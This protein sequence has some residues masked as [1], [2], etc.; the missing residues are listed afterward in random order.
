MQRIDFVAMGC[1][2]AVFHDSDA[3]E[4]IAL[5]Q[6]VPTWF[7]E[8]EQALSRF[9]P[10]SELSA[11]N[12]FAGYWFQ[13]SEVLWDVLVAALDGAARTAGRVTPT[14]LP[15]L[16]AAG[17]DRSFEL[18]AEDEAVDHPDVGPASDHG[19]I[20]MDPLR[21]TV[22][23]P[24]G[25]A[26]DLGGVA[27]GWAAERAAQRLAH[28]GGVLVDA[29]GDIAA[30]GRRHLDEPWPIAVTDPRAADGHEIDLPTL[31]LLSAGG[32]A[33]SGRDH[34]R[35]R[36]HG[37]TQ[38][39][40]IDPSTGRP[41]DTDV[42]TATV[43]AADAVAAEIMA[44]HL[45]LLGCDDGLRW[46]DAQPDAAALIVTDDGALHFS[47]RFDRYSWHAEATSISS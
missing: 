30:R 32:I 29:G 7:E 20:A 24:Q 45:V 9:R 39:H 41:T 14:I 5:L 3:P 4:A 44:K 37:R 6:Q 2:V 11:L 25:V 35:W 43:I 21:R 36:R 17:Y 27:K 31:V 19:T 34:R 26:L 40:I 47:S 16:L 13:P 28:L 38:H 42:L 33:T 22:R 46:I 12:R 15:Q 23:L 1:D 8:W 18:I 10:S